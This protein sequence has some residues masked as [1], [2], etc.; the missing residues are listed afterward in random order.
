MLYYGKYYFD[1]FVHFRQ[2]RGKVRA[3]LH[4]WFPIYLN[5]LKELLEIIFFNPYIVF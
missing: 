2:D 1:F 4:A 5:L 3:I